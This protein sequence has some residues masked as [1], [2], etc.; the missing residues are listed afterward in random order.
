M[1]V[2]KLLKFNRKLTDQLTKVCRPKQ[3]SL[4][5]YHTVLRVS[6]GVDRQ[7]ALIFTATLKI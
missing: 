6:V 5:S 3:H 4:M 2:A 7:Q 1:L